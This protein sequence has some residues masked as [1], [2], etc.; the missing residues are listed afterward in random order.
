[1]IDP[2]RPEDVPP[3]GESRSG[4][5]DGGPRRRGSRSGDSRAGADG[6]PRPAAAIAGLALGLLGLGMGL[7]PSV[8]RAGLWLL[9]LPLLG[10]PLS[11]GGAALGYVARARALRDDAPLGWG[12]AALGTGVAATLLCAAWTAVLLYVGFGTPRPQLRRQLAPVPASP[13]ARAPAPAPAPPG[14]C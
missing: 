8:P 2:A 14:A 11:L 13:A 1:M 12:T 3:L 5:S 6:D 9:F 10:L 7:G 4:R